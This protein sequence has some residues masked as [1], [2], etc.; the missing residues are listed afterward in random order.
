MTRRALIAQAAS[1]LGKIN[2]Y[3][4]E[5][6]KFVGIYSPSSYLDPAFAVGGDATVGWA[7]IPHDGWPVAEAQQAIRDYSFKANCKAWTENTNDN[8]AEIWEARDV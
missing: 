6:L 7:S 8:V 4:S 3:T 2:V 1:L 5:P